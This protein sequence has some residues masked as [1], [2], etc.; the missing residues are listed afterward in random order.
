MVPMFPKGFSLYFFSL[1]RDFLKIE[2]SDEGIGIATDELDKLFQPFERLESPLKVLA[3]GTGLG[4]Y[5]TRKI[6]EDLMRGEVYVRSTLGQGST[7]GL[8]IPSSPT[9]L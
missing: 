6:V 5:L 4:L 3:G 1:R 8:R 2:V 9:T 7:F